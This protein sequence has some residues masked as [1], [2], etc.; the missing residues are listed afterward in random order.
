MAGA[1]YA[2]VRLKMAIGGEE[3]QV[4][5]FTEDIWQ[6]VQYPDSVS[7]FLESLNGS[8]RGKEKQYGL[9]LQV[10]WHCYLSTEGLTQLEVAEKIEVSDS[11]VSDYRKRIENCLRHLSFG[12]VSEARHFEKELRKKV[13]ELVGVDEEK[14]AL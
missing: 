7:G 14:P 12:D 10:L 1:S 3:T 4:S 11:L 2:E 5:S 9:M 6:E 8:V 13:R